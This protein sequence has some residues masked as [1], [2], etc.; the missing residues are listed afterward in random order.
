ML[1]QRILTAII[2]LGGLLLGLFR[3]N[4]TGWAIL[5][6]LPFGGGLLEWGKL[7]GLSVRMSMVYTVLAIALS[8]LFYYSHEFV[9]LYVCAAL[10]WLLIVPVWLVAAWRSKSVWLNVSL[11]Y[12]VLAPMWLALVE[13]RA[14]GPWWVL[15]M[16]GVVWVA[17]SAAY[18]SGRLFGRHKL[19]PDISPGKSWEGVL[20]ALFAVMAYGGLVLYVLSGPAFNPV[21]WGLPVMLLMGLMLYLSVLGDL[22]ESWMKRLAQVKDSGNLLPGHGGMLD[23]VDALTSSLPVGTLILLHPDVLRHIF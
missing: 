1:A 14:H 8:G 22:F 10:L 20:G 4:E 2:L 21:A 9:W 5:M 11:G 13:L 3:L 17:D 18:F 23:R 19:A 12:F 15:L 6:L 7:S 16:M